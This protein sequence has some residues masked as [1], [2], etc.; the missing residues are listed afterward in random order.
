[1]RTKKLQLYDALSYVV[2]IGAPIL[3][4]TALGW[5]VHKMKY[6]NLINKGETHDNQI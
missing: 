6:D 2:V 4:G 3:M 1:M 5:V